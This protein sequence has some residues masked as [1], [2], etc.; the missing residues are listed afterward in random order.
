MTDEGDF[1]TG[2]DVGDVLASDRPLNGGHDT[3]VSARKVFTA[4]DGHRVQRPLSL[5]RHSHRQQQVASD[6]HN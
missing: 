1:D 5:Q 2:V 6:N 4:V 3:E